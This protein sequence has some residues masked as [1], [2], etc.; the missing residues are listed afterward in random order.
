LFG[1]SI[2]L[3][4]LQNEIVAWRAISQVI[5]LAYL[6]EQETSLIILVPSG[7]SIFIEVTKINLNQFI[8]HL[9]NVLYFI[10]IWKLY[11]AFKVKI[12][13]NSLVIPSFTVKP[14]KIF[15]I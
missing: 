2:K 13:F 1:Q 9:Y 4:F 14:K 15:S 5:I 11:K 3:K 12:E 8:V 7:M 10:K 6:F